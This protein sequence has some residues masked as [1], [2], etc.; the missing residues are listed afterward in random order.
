MLSY[1]FLGVDGKFLMHESSVI[2]AVATWCPTAFYL[3]VRD[4]GIREMEGSTA[5]IA[6]V[7]AI[8]IR[9]GKQLAPGSPLIVQ[10]NGVLEALDK[11]EGDEFEMIRFTTHG[12][13]KGIVMAESGLPIFAFPLPSGEEFE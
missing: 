3:A 1:S 13:L 12:G 11:L 9:R 5:S 7:R 2:D 4:S 10:V 6:A 8:Y